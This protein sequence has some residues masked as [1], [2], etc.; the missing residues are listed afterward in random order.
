[1]VVLQEV[2]SASAENNFA[3]PATTVAAHDE[4]IGIAILG[5]FLQVAGHRAAIRRDPISSPP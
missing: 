1:M 2:L 4:K 5:R 3:C